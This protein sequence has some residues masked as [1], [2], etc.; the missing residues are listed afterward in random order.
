[1]NRWTYGFVM[2]YFVVHT[3]FGTILSSRVSE[4][5]RWGMYWVLVGMV[6]VLVFNALAN[7]VRRLANANSSA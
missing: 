5:T 7:K 6:A 2:I 3:A 1:M 4:P